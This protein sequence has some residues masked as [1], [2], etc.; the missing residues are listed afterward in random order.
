MSYSPGRLCKAPYL[1]AYRV[2]G[3]LSHPW[4]QAL[5]HFTAVESEAWRGKVKGPQGWEGP[6]HFQF[7]I[8]EVLILL[9]M[10]RCQNRAII[11]VVTS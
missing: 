9:K 4:T 1:P 2:S 10:W 11:I 7:F 8:V 5:P 3:V 6:S